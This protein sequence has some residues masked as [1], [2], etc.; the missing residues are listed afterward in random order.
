MIL[1]DR[2]IRERQSMIRPYNEDQLQ[3]ASYD[4]RLDHAEHETIMPGESMLGVTK[5]YIVIPP[6]LVGMV[7]G[8]STVAREFL[9]V[10]YAGF[11]DPG[12]KGR[13]VLEFTN[14]S[15]REIRFD[16]YKTICQIAFV[17]MS[18]IPESLYGERDNHY[19]DQRDI[20]KSWIQEE[21][22]K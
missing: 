8:K 14:N 22:R 16:R 9:N 21:E 1:S 18:E 3:M 12:F 15:N 4:L 10:H 13:I 5:E 11:I 2:E 17:K 7:F 6:D 20:K 19:Q